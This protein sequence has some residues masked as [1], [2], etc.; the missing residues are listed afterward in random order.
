MA[1][2]RIV[3]H[4]VKSLDGI[5]RRSAQITTGGILEGD[6][7]YAIFDTEG[8]VVNAKRTARIQQLRSAFDETLSEISVR[9]E[10]QGHAE[11]FVLSEPEPLQEWLGEFFG[12]PVFLRHE[13][14]RGFPDDTTA[15]GP[16]LITAATL[17]AV[18]GWF[19][20]VP[21]ASLPRRFRTNLEIAGTPAFWEDS[22]YGLAGEL[23]SFAIGAV[24]LLAHNAC[25]RCAVPARDP[26]SGAATPDF[27]KVF[28]KLR[29]EHLPAWAERS[30][31]NHFY[32]LAVNTSIPSTEAGKILRVGDPISPAGSASTVPA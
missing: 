22:L 32:R 16:T 18:A 5:E 7:V 4:P 10:G 9:E 28:L 8:R 23:R 3:I 2:G 31:F 11:T 24:R 14:E 30:R 20:G 15:F 19:P 25:Q 29:E 27:Q 13:P 26:D 17:E 12:F 1:L 6:R 21:A